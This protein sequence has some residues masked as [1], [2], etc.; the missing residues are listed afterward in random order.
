ME[1]SGMLLSRSAAAQLGL[2]AYPEPGKLSYGTEKGWPWRG[3]EG[4]LGP[5]REFAGGRLGCPYPDALCR[6]K[7]GAELPALLPPRN[8]QPKAGWGDPCKEHPEPRWA[9]AVL[10]PLALYS[11]AYHR[12]PLPGPGLD[13]PL[14]G[15]AGKPR[16][17]AGEAAGDP[18]AFRHCPFLVEAK[19]SPFLLSSLLPT[20]P[21][22][23]PPFG[24]AGAEGPGAVGDGRFASPDWRLG[25]YAAAWG[26]PLYLGVPPRGKAAPA[27]LECSGS[28][29][30][31]GHLGEAP[32]RDARRCPRS[33]GPAAAPARPER[34]WR[35]ATLPPGQGWQHPREVQAATARHG[36]VP[37][38]P[39][40]AVSPPVMPPPG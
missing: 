4:C 38:P 22:A 14:P 24:G 9:E 40:S 17:A 12:Y 2:P 10:A 32:Q 23:E 1:S 37:T 20:G 27:P 18:P 11:H 36:G 34:G 16:S 29:N 30:K 39:S 6:P 33:P 7:A 26:Q 5:V 19:H 28:G 35:K 3:S 21:P 25:P 31:V 15:T 13:A 8:G